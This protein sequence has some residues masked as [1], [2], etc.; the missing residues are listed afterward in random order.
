MD[1]IDV[2]LRDG[3][4]SLWGATGLTT[5]HILEIAPLLNR[6]GF[7]AADFTSSTHMGVAVRTHRED[8]WERIRL[9]HQAMPD[10]PLQFIGTGLRFISWETV[11]PDFLEL[12]YTRLVANGI[13]R[14]M[15]MDSTHDWPAVLAT[16]QMTRRAGGSEIV[17]GLIYTISPVHDDAFYADFAA[18]MAATDT[19]DRVYIKDPA[20]LLT[21]ERARTLIPAVQKAP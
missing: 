17:G 13:S 16:S 11:H 14:F 12:A 19:I 2:S 1:L 3:N 21:P 18:K 4:Q 5:G 15:V 20:G 7:R 6:V 8:P 9:T 10:T